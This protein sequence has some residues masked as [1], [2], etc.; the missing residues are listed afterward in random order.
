MTCFILRVQ[1][2]DVRVQP[3]EFTGTFVNCGNRE[4]NSLSVCIG[5]LLKIELSAAGSDLLG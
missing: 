4:T 3:R 5:R 1:V 2:F